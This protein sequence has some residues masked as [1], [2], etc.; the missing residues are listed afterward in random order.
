MHFKSLPVGKYMIPVQSY[1]GTFGKD[2]SFYFRAMA[3]TAE[4]TLGDAL[5]ANVLA[6]KNDVMKCDR[7]I[8]SS[9][10]NFGTCKVLDQ[11]MQCYRKTDDCTYAACQSGKY[12]NYLRGCQTSFQA[13]HPSAKQFLNP[14]TVAK[15]KENY[16]DC[17]KEICENKVFK[18]FETC[19]VGG[20]N[21]AKALIT[22][23][24]ANK[25]LADEI[26]A[27]AEKDQKDAAAKAEADAKAAKLAAYEYYQGTGHWIIGN[28]CVQLNG[29][30]VGN[31]ENDAKL[32]ANN[33]RGTPP[34]LEKDLCMF[35]GYT[36]KTTY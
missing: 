16:D 24:A 17:T 14:E 31:E 22:N 13:K 26:E 23:V 3:Q 36:K 18:A 33:F 9:F 2:S 15:C 1:G 6:C 35:S 19:K 5:P 34:K 4:V 29:A 7:N 21:A 10:Q 30:K 8:C 25:K 27:R 28:Q 32:Y 12:F 11:V 20:A